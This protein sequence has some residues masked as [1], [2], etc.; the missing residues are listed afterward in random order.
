MTRYIIRKLIALPLLL[1][2]VSII[3]YAMI[4]AIPGD[5]VTAL[6]SPEIP[7]SALEARREALGLN[8]PAYV[9]YVLWLGELMH[10]N[11]G[12]SFVDRRPVAT[13]IMERAG[14]TLTL[15]GT[16]LLLALVIGLPLGIFAALKK[17]TTSDYVLSISAFT[18]VS[19]PHF[20]LGLIF[21]YIFAITLRILPTGGKYELGSERTFFDLLRHL[22]M[23]AIVLALEE[24]AVYMRLIRGNILEVMGEDYIR[25]ARSKGLND[26]QTLIHH[27]LPNSILPIITRLGLTL[28]WLFSGAVV[29]EQVFQWPGIGM[30]TIDALKY[31]DYPVIM[32][33][34]LIASSLVVAGNLLAD[35]MYALVDPR[36]HYD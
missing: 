23:P 15:M 21:I 11:L 24:L 3:V 4:E 19:I 31:R 14:S 2:A 13:K 9:R 34:N 33:V 36:I 27:A 8:K 7:R 28:A 22:V 6:I 16:G 20:F 32:S 30:L 29:T 17:Y 35:I 1:F 5:P 10:G 26:R 18:A 25:T 12:Y